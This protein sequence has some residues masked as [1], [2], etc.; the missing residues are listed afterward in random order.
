ML[1]FQYNIAS[2]V[3]LFPHRWTPRARDRQQ[4]LSPPAHL[5][6]ICACTYFMHVVEQ[7]CFYAECDQ[8]QA[9]QQQQRTI[10][11]YPYTKANKQEYKGFFP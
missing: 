7:Q 9:G 1:Y 3:P 4:R 8:S 6:T 2:R 5:K 10:I 11:S